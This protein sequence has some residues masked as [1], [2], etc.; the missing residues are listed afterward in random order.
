MSQ[1]CQ[2]KL[3][4]KGDCVETSKVEINLREDAVIV[5]KNG[6]VQRI[7]KPDSGFGETSI[8]WQNGK[9]H[10]KKVSYTMK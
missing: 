6:E 10:A 3:R 9:I 7:P 5:V 4:N 1:L 2:S 8:T